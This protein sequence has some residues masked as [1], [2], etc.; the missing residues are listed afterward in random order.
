MPSGIEIVASSI[1]NLAN[2]STAEAIGLSFVSDG[3][4]AS[5]LIGV[6]FPLGLVVNHRRFSSDML[7]RE[8]RH[9]ERVS[10]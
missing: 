9:V 6:R 5:G 3:V 4:K 7:H 10:V 1:R 8:T 2:C